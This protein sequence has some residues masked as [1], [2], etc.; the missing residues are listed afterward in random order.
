VGRQKED[1]S[2]V[3]LAKW[4]VVD[5]SGGSAV[6][7]QVDGDKSWITALKTFGYA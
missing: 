5:V 7:L 1:V 6:D 2:E 4:C 3:T